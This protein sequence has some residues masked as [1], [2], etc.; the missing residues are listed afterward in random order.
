MLN[1]LGL[2]DEQIVKMGERLTHSHTQQYILE[3][4]MLSGINNMLTWVLG[5]IAFYL[6]TLVFAS[7]THD[8]AFMKTASVGHFSLTH[9]FFIIYSN[10]LVPPRNGYFYSLLRC[11]WIGRIPRRSKDVGA[12]PPGSRPV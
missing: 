12:I 9:F 5:L 4:G 1:N 3:N 2:S 10:L 11:N 8:S 6:I 7:F